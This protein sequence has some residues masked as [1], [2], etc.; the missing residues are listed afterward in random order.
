MATT[1]SVPAVVLIGLVRGSTTHFPP[2][3]QCTRQAAA[4]SVGALIQAGL[5]AR[6]LYLQEVSTKLLLVDPS[7]PPVAQS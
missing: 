3:G 5:D 7:S 2:L 6:T 1:Y 4:A